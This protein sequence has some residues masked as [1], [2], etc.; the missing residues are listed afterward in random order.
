[1]ISS[2]TQEAIA[3]LP[4]DIKLKWLVLDVVHA[5]DSVL[6]IALL[7]VSYKSKAAAATSIAVLDHHL[8]HVHG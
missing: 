6:G 2:Y 7:G 3:K 4:C 8:F 1:M 5:C